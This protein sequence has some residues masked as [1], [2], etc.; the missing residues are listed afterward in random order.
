VKKVLLKKLY[1]DNFKSFKKSSFKFEKLNCLIAPNNAGKSNLLEALDF[2]NGLLYSN[3]QNAIA[4]LGFEKMANYHYNEK[5]V[6]LNAEFEV[7]NSVLVGNRFVT[8]ST[9]FIYLFSLDL[10]SRKFN[11]DVIMN[12]KLKYLDVASE[13]L[14]ESFVEFDLKIYNDYIVDNLKNYVE[15]KNELD[16]KRFSKFYLEYNLVKN[17]CKIEANSN[18]LKTLKRIFALTFLNG[19]LVTPFKFQNIFN[20]IGLFQSYYFDINEVKKPE[21]TGMKSLEKNGKNLV[22]YLD[23]L[24]KNS[25]EIFEKISTSIISEV[26]LIQGIE[27]DNSSFVPQLLFQEEHNNKNYNV[28][29]DTISDGTLHFIAI[30]SALYGNDNF[31]GLMIE[32]PERHMHMKTL[33]HILNSMRDDNK[34]IFFTTHSTE[35][36]Q[37]LELNEI[38][39]VFRD[40]DG[41]TQGKRAK[42]IE[43][44]K[45]IM[46]LF[47]GNLVE[48]IQTGVLGEYDE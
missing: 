3:P 26:D 35:I 25:N 8:Y 41:D 40:Y 4:K 38:L 45:K 44:I 1:L 32:E 10:E 39:F 36:L 6:S 21:V 23:F 18:V 46:E 31:L 48:M 42:D 30:M 20:N 24:A 19:E 9:T 33:S 22:E 34:Q 29:I 5:I 15:Y 27:I 16:K 13:D 12:G 17:S 2:L 14:Q 28:D 47:K 7:E 11:I 43:N 37:Q